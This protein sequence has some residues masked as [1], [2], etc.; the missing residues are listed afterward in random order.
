MKEEEYEKELCIR[1]SLTHELI[2]SMGAAIID[3]NNGDPDF[4]EWIREGYEQNGLEKF[5]TGAEFYASRRPWIE[6]LSRGESGAALNPTQEAYIDNNI[7][8]S[9]LLSEVLS[10]EQLVENGEKE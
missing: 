9:E 1:A 3:F 5:K 4:F 7:W 8:L 10:V 2:A 6:A